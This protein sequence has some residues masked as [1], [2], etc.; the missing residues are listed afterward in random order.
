MTERT[1]ASKSGPVPLLYT[2]PNLDT[3]GSGFA[4]L[5]IIRRL[6]RSRFAPAICVLRRGGRLEAEVEEPRCP[7][8]RGAVRDQPLPAEY[9][10]LAGLPGVPPVSRP[11]GF[12]LWH[13]YHY[14]DDYSEPLIA[15]LARRPGLGVHEEEHGLESRVGAAH[16]LVHAR[17]G[18]ELLDAAGRCS[19]ASPPAAR[20]PCC[21][22]ASRRTDFIP[23]LPTG[24]SCGEKLG[25]PPGA[26][27]VGSVA[28]LVAVKGHP[29]LIDAIARVPGC[30]LWLA[31]KELDA[32][33]AEGLRRQI[34]QL[35]IGDRVFFLGSI[36]DVPAL[37]AELDVTVLASKNEGCPVALLEAMA[38]GR[39][40]IATSIP[41]PLD[42]V[43]D[44]RNGRLVPYGDA[45]ALAGA[46]QDLTSSA[47]L[48]RELGAA[49]RRRVVDRYSIDGEVRA[50][51]ELY[52]K[53][54]AGSSD[55][56]APLAAR[57]MT[58]SG[59]AG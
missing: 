21:P 49:A 50:Y 11:R 12:T 29:V 54:L 23:T 14:L 26:V 31:G 51:E 28:N 9:V 5:S 16:V 19:H 8:L 22:P 4:M 43:D 18:A 41:G 36:A 13:S 47:E 38:G 37:L 20:R 39:A 34:A 53:A 57:A 1:H 15:R 25:L 55:R 32:R 35:G 59:G 24:C 30:Y 56:D 52:E 17:R 58:D 40:C 7:V 48:R 33:Y 6:D 45:V 27:V 46:I 2:I 44:G 10:S 3:A 42:V